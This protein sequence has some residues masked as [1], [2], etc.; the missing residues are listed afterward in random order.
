MMRE[1]GGLVLVVQAAHVSLAQGPLR[2]LAVPYERAHGEPPVS[3]F[4]YV[5]QAEGVPPLVGHDGLQVVLV[6][7]RPGAGVRRPLEVRLVDLDV[8]FDDLVVAR[9]VALPPGTRSGEDAAREIPE[10]H[11]ANLVALLAV[12]PAY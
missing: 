9:G 12:G 3:L 5:I 8:G 4:G 7:A 11:N 2:L 6:P 1:L 10:G